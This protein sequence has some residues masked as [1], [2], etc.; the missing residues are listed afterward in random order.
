MTVRAI[1]EDKG[2]DVVTMR[3]DQSLAE[4]TRLMAE[5]RIGAVVV[6]RSDGRTASPRRSWSAIAACIAPTTPTTAPSTPACAQLGISSAGG[7][8]SKR[9]RTHAPPRITGRSCP[10]KRSAPA[11]TSGT[12]SRMATSEQRNLVWKLSEPSRTTSCPA[13]SAAAFS[14]STRSRGTRR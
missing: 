14:A 9:Q 13:K 8:C 4:A 7:S 1:L 5:R 3:P 11:W 12:A 6:T 2:R 10:A